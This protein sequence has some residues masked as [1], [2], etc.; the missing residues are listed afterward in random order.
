M[1]SEISIK[2]STG[3]FSQYNKTKKI[4]QSYKDRI[5]R[6]NT[7]LADKIF[8]YVGNSNEIADILELKKEFSKYIR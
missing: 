2:H 3:D 1:I 6:N 7:L 5:R 4:N 8:A